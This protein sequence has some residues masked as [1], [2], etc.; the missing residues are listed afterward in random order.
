MTKN[1]TAT[2]KIKLVK[3]YNNYDFLNSPPART[4]R[5][6]AELIEPADRLRRKD[7]Q[8]TVVFFG[9]ART[10]PMAAARSNLNKIRQKIKN[11]K[12]PKK[13]LGDEKA[14][15]ERDV[16][17]AQYY[18]DA[19]ELAEKLTRWFLEP[20]NCFDKFLI[21]S[22]GGPGIMEAANRGARTAGGQSIGLNISLPFEQTPN[23]YQS[24]ELSFD[25]HYFFIRKFWFF[26][27]A[28]ALV[29]FPGGY[30][31]LDEFFELLTLIQTG[32]TK[33]YMPVILYGRKFWKEI[34][35]FNG[36][37]KWGVISQNDLKLFKIYDTVD[38]AFEYLTKE[39]KKHYLSKYRR[40]GKNR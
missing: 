9:S 16:I 10:L 31:T 5:V 26:Y 23:P 35:N 2:K 21:C 18:E 30:G 4:L 14:Q 39:L 12:S 7:I 11:N 36:F 15:A 27:L 29:V 25:F 17:M 24:K 22:G 19:N 1:R 13:K 37:V 20:K 8:D 3:A 40:K 6:L 34:L 32:K 28:K 38:S 33:K